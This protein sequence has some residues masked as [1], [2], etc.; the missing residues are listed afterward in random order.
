MKNAM[1]LRALSKKIAKENNTTAQVILQNYMLEHFLLR[2]SSS[3]FRSK[4][5]QELNFLL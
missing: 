3:R 1:Q 5:I 2:L 4:F